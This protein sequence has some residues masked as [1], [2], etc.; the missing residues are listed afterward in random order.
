MY[1]S[2]AS[3]KK[4]TGPVGRFLKRHASHTPVGRIDWGDLG[5]IQPLSKSWG[6]DR[7]LPIDRYYI[8]QFLSTYASDIRGRV[9]EIGDNEYTRRYGGERVS[10][11]DILH[12]VPGNPK[13]TL[14]ADL[15]S[16]PQLPSETFDCIICTQTLQLIYDL[17]GAAA[18]VYRLLKPGGVLL[19][20]VPGICRI[21]HGDGVLG[22]YWRFTV[23]AVQRLFAGACP[24]AEVHIESHGN[25]LAAIAFLH[26]LAKEELR[27]E[28][29]NAHDPDYQLLVT[30]RVA[31]PKTS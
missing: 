11:S 23:A 5:Q 4:V 28:A 19:A 27:P 2:P 18:T 7:G 24:R 8:E 29:L 13:A 20:T 31:K 26:G 17:P 3:L 9:L 22:D 16:A 10:K 12:V 1:H 21:A 25:V 30:A 15:A 6:F 14:V